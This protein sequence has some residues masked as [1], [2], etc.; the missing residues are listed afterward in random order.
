MDDKE[1]IG[2]EPAQ[3]A[4]LRQ[5]AERRL[6]AKKAKPA[7]DMAEVDVLAL[8]HEL[9]VHQIELEMQNEELLRAQTAVQ[10]ASDKYHGLFDF[11]P[12]GYFRL[13]AQ[14][15]I[16]EV[17]LAGAV[18]LGLDRSTA[19]KHRLGQFVAMEHRAEFAE[20]CKRVL[21]TD[22]KQACEVE[23]RRNGEPV[24]VMMEGISAQ[25]G[26][27]SHSLHVTVTDATDRKQAES[28]REITIELFRLLSQTNH[29]HELIRSVT[30]LLHEWSG[31]EAV[32]VRLHDGEDF[33]YFETRGFPPE[34]VLAENRLCEVDARGELR[35]DISG[36]PVL[37]CMCGN[38]IRGRFDPSKP[39]FTAGG[40][41]WTNCT[42]E[43]LASTTEADR[44][45]RT[46]NRCN[47]EGYESVALIPLRASGETFG[48]LQLNDRRRGRFTSRQISL[49]ERLADSLALALENQ[50]SR[51]S[52][53]ERDEFQRDMINAL[54][55]HIA[56]L[57]REGTIV[58][59]NAAW[60]R[61]ARENGVEHAKC[62]GIGSNYLD[63]CRNASGAFRA[64]A[65]AAMEGI[66]AVLLGER[67]SFWLEYPCHSPDQPRWFVMHATPLSHRTGGAIISHVN[68]TERKQV[69]ESLRESE[70][71]FRSLIENAPE[72][73]FLQ[74]ADRFA[75]LNMAACKLFGASRPEE[76]LGK[77]FMERMAP[78]HHDAIRERIRLQHGTGE[79]VPL[80]EQ[81]YL[82]L[83]GSRVPVETT[84]V[85]IRYQGDDAHLVFAR[86]ITNRKRAVEELRQEKEFTD[87]VIS[88]AGEG[89][90][91][92][93]RHLRYVIWNRFMEDL[94]GMSTEQVLGR[95]AFGLFPHLR[96]CGIDRLLERAIAVE[97]VFSAD[98]PYR[99]PSTERSGWV[100]ATYGPQRDVNGNVIGVIGIVRDVTARKQAEI[101][102]QESEERLRLAAE[103]AEFGTY[104]HNL[105]TGE[106]CWSPEF[107]AILGLA[108]DAPCQTGE[109][110]VLPGV[111]PEDR[112]ALVERLK[113]SL[114]PQGPGLLNA[115]FRAIRPN[116]S[117]R[118]VS[119]HGR[120]F[121]L[122]E[123]QARH[124]VRAAGALIDI[125]DRRRTEELLRESTRRQAEA[126]R[127]AATGR[128]AA[129]V[130]HEI[131]NP[132]AGIKNSFRLIRDA[133]PLDHP[134]RDMVA[135]IEREIDRIALVI[136]Q[137]YQIYSPRSEDLTDIPVGET[138]RD[139][140]ALLEPL[141]CENE[142]TVEL[143]AVSP[144]LM[145]RAYPGGLQQ[146]L[147]NLVT[148][149]IHAS[150]RAAVVHV[151]AELAGEDYVK[152]SIRDRGPGI[153]AKM[154]ARMFE[155][156]VSADT[157][158]ATAGGLGLGLGLSIVKSIVDSLRGR[159]EF[160]SML[161][162]GTCF[163]V[164]LPSK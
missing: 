115:E 48:L 131:N 128:M 88:N 6:L 46:R 82:R 132:L 8:V 31:C 16:L 25:T 140:L 3:A 137:M 149:A 92:Y 122:G 120:V 111:H 55:A 113:A 11:A 151:A 125:T 35:R 98:V 103:A 126:E 1:A 114:D 69:E 56:V 112:P 72:A 90:V 162:E 41:F 76:L 117:V 52:L 29:R 155:P 148:N 121:F 80:M 84:A 109:D 124:P 135:R 127:L 99:V 2:S 39:F 47:G 34:F 49:L 37:E 12:V 100:T 156:F 150:P 101:S 71:R 21:A 61:F 58:A 43:L 118:W 146:V 54:A 60:D 83:D 40:S 94:T 20:F 130:A 28:E 38:V 32:G 63:V 24:C 19:I 18:I 158:N 75:Y 86:D 157:G 9:Q 153:P 50:K 97:T 147:Y 152:I 30:A 27:A 160:E 89:I 15:R 142:V 119:A 106:A 110:F 7:K 163:R 65:E 33:P 87:H 36:N 79:P 44:Q 85:L 133:V 138:I 141:R 78:E 116:G 104:S 144:A 129:L 143:A 77:D 105:L 164:Y 17:N 62:T 154:Q 23:L 67:P 66:Q 42:T 22:A 123:G 64:E 26:G 93:D 74:I 145:V 13:G 45:A 102:L 134:D 91:V 5:E 59:V 81:E 73:V 136:R 4:D 139:V 10:E 57:D 68:I 51:E 108:P 14:G 95:H 96:E 70:A 159:I 107:K 161:G 53:R